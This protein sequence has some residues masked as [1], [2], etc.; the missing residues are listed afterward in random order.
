MNQNFDKTN[1]YDT[2]LSGMMREMIKYCS[3]NGIPVFI[4]ACIKN[5]NKESVYRSDMVSAASAG[6]NLTDDRLIRYVNVLNGFD[7][8]PPADKMKMD[9]SLWDEAEE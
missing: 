4:S 8:V 1:E 5:D 9:D 7:T 2:K 6:V 3:V